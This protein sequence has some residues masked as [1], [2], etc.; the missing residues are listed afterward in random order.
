MNIVASFSSE[1]GGIIILSPEIGSREWTAYIFYAIGDGVRLVEQHA[2]EHPRAAEVI[3]NIRSN[4]LLPATAEKKPVLLPPSLC[5]S[6][7]G[8][9]VAYAA[10]LSGGALSTVIYRGNSGV[11]IGAQVSTNP[12]FPDAFISWVDPGDVHTFAVFY[13]QD[14]VARTLRSLSW[15]NSKT[16]RSVVELMGRGTLPKRTDKPAVL[17]TGQLAG[18]LNSVY[19]LQREIR[20]SAN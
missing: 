8:Q 2:S 3:A 19:V 12:A 7:L 6:T 1:D 11:I 18:F 10:T 17:I 9:L 13:S 4:P 16:R 14:D 15:L 20:E 5:V